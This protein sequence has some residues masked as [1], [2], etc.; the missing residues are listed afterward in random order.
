MQAWRV[1]LLDRVLEQ[2]DGAVEDVE[3]VAEMVDLLGPRD[4]VE[5]GARGD[6]PHP[7]VGVFEQFGD[8]GDAL[9][10]EPSELGVGKIDGVPAD[11]LEFRSE[12]GVLHPAVEGDAADAGGLR[13]L[14]HGGVGGDVGHGQGLLGSEV[15]VSFLYFILFHSV[16]P[17]RGPGHP[18]VTRPFRRVRAV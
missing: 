1:L 14:G 6:G 17:P 15:Y 9:E 16:T 18:H 4:V 13:S 12:R 2:A 8:G 11:T 10:R 5:G 7:G 3:A